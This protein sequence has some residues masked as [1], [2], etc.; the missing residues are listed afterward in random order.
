[1]IHYIL[2]VLYLKQ[3]NVFCNQLNLQNTFTNVYDTNVL[4][5]F[6]FKYKDIN[7]YNFIIK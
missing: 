5:L 1:M 4:I 3:L 7:L 6:Y 2:L